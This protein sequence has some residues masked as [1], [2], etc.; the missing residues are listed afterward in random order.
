[1]GSGSFLDSGCAFAFEVR[2]GR[3]AVAVSILLTAA[4]V[5]TVAVATATG[6]AL[7]DLVAMTASLAGLGALVLASATAF[8]VLK[9]VGAAYLVWL[10]I[11]MWRS[12]GNL[13]AAY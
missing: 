12:R 6:V 2:C 9:W 7:G 5:S 4:T 1:M 10:G 8:L 11:E 3:S 13:V